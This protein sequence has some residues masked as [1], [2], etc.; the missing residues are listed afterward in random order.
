MATVELGGYR[1]YRGDPFAEGGVGI[2]DDMPPFDQPGTEYVSDRHK[3]D[4]PSISEAE[5]KK[6]L[7]L[8]AE[9]AIQQRRYRKGN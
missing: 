1:T 6:L 8:A 5:R 4:E 7:Q 3:N 9:S 2:I